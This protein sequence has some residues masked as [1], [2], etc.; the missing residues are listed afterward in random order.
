MR[1]IIVR[2]SRPLRRAF[3]LLV[4]AAATHLLL[5]LAIAAG[6]AFPLLAL[7]PVAAVLPAELETIALGTA[8]GLA[9]LSAVASWHVYTL[10]P[11]ARG[12]AIV[13]SYASL[14]NVPL[15]MIVG[16]VTLAHLHEPRVRNVLIERERVRRRE[17]AG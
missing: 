6:N 16:L 9:T 2:R 3:F 13:S 5:A 8:L 10:T 7:A 14:V 4:L 12:L 11:F 1:R 15:G 17:T